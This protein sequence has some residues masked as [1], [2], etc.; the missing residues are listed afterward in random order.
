MTS[1]GQFNP[2]IAYDRL[3]VIAS[4][5]TVSSV[6]DTRGGIITGLILPAAFTGTAITFQV[7]DKVDGTFVALYDETNTAISLTVAQGRGYK[8]DPSLLAGWRFVKIV[9]GSAEGAIRSVI[10]SIRAVN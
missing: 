2:A 9:S 7:S 10:L 6:V 5:A 3:A 4:G 8:I 1:T